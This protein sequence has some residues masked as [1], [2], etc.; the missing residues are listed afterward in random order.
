M[1][2]FLV[3]DHQMFRQGL[4]T[5]LE[6][7]S[8]IHVVG[9]AGDG[10]EGLK[11]IEKLQ[12]DVAVLDIAMAGLSGI[13][14]TKQLQKRV[15]DCRILVL[16]MHADSFFAVES[17][18]AGALGFLLKEESFDRFIDALRCVAA[19]NTFISPSL[20]T[21]VL[22]ELVGIARKS[23][24]RSKDILTVREREILQLVAEGMTNQ[25]IADTLCI[26]SSTVDTHRKNIMTKL[27]V[28]SV[29]GLVKYAIRHKIV[30]L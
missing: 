30:I 8:D 11:E 24:D 3:D 25:E 15:P 12:P 28:H 27:D 21:V 16:T 20:K 1:N 18:K 4:R 5:L 13:D 7:T 9:E 19:G 22:E 23:K 14:V 6:G 29:A 10:R 26:S 2:V 17:L